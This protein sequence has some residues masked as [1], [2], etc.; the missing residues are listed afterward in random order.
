MSSMMKN[1][2][3]I[4]QRQQRTEEEANELKEGWT[5]RM[6]PHEVS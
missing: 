1:L 4:H 6:Q 5:K 2:K 3:E